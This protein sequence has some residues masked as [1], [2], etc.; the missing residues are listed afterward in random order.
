PLVTYRGRTRAD[1]DGS[2]EANHDDAARVG[3]CN[4]WRARDKPD[5]RHA[6][7]DCSGNEQCIDQPA[8]LAVA[9]KRAHSAGPYVISGSVSG[10]P[11]LLSRRLRLRATITRHMNELVT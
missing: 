10:S 6:G 7:D 5:H 1:G 3:Q 4:R 11:N 9:G 8:R 2:K